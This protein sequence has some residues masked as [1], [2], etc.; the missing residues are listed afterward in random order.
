MRK[1]LKISQA[2]QTARA[3]STCLENWFFF[4]LRNYLC[5]IRWISAVYTKSNFLM[6]GSGK[7]TYVC[8]CVCIGG[9]GARTTC[10]N[11]FPSSTMWVP[12]VSPNNNASCVNALSWCMSVRTVGAYKM[13]WH[14]PTFTSQFFLFTTGRVYCGIWRVNLTPTIAHCKPW[15]LSAF[16]FCEKRNYTGKR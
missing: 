8:L 3:V 7:C 10:G 9:G 11:P 12:S 14:F 4:I 2:L 6:I 15:F 13:G 1:N 5:Q 16:Q